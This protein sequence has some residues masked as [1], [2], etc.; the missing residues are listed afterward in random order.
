LALRFGPLTTLITRR[1]EDE[2]EVQYLLAPGVGA[3]PLG[4]FIERLPP[5]VRKSSVKRCSCI[6]SSTRQSRGLATAGQS[7]E[8]G[9][10]VT[11]AQDVVN[12]PSLIHGLYKKRFG[13]KMGTGTNNHS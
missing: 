7:S 10:S 9:N 4:R 8:S 3:E 12:R 6:C 11:G 1:T 2:L 13:P 5:R